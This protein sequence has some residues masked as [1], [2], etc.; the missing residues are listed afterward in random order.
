MRD[1]LIFKEDEGF[2]ACAGI[3]F[4]VLMSILDYNIELILRLQCKYP[5][6]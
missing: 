4:I 6:W 3:C 5:H 2:V 1:K